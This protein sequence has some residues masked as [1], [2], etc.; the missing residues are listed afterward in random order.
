[1]ETGQQ[2]RLAG[3]GE[4]G[5]NG[6]PYGDLYGSGFC[7]SQ[8]LSLNVKEQLSSTISTSTLS[9]QLLVILLKF[10]LFTEMLNWLSQREH[11][12]V[13][14]SVYVAKELRAFVA[15]QL[16]TNMLLLMSC[17]TDRL[18]R[19]SKSSA[20]RIAAAG[21]FKVNPKKSVFGPYIK[22]PLKENKAERAERLFCL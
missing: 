11:R 18:K 1:M 16:V 12:L 14:N 8:R 7:G 21:D 5:F 19:P 9:K 2:I 3:Q 22:M 13:R 20:E 6:G 10:Q 17:N 4:A 15:V